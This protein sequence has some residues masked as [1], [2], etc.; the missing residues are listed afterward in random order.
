MDP[1]TSLP[2][3][4]RLIGKTEIQLPPQR[5]SQSYRVARGVL[6]LRRDFLVVIWGHIAVAKEVTALFRAAFHPCSGLYP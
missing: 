5:T 3:V 1:G 6:G 2:N 4:E